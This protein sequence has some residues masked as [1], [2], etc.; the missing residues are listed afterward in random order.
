M[1]SRPAEAAPSEEPRR[2]FSVAVFARFRGR[3]LLIHHT[4]LGTWLPV[5]GEIE[6][7]ETP[8]LAAARE[9]QEETGLIG[10]FTALCGV[11]GTPR[12]LIG[13]EEH[14]AG[15]KGLHMNFAFVADVDS[16]VVRSNGEFTDHRFVDDPTTLDCPENV[17]Q[18]CAMALTESE[19]PLVHLAR[20]WLHTFNTR[21]L[22]GLLALYADDAVHTSPKLRLRHPETKGEVRGKDALRAWWKDAMERLPELRYDELHL[23]ADKRR[24]VMEYMRVCPPEESYVVAETLVVEK[25]LIVASHVF[26]G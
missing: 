24:V 2:A 17:R 25:G 21:D 13:Y 12:G 20:R 7:G 1:T 3:V 16:D 10:R 4:R 11:D 14:M 23:T 18:L 6:P 19:S 15:K 9:L 5:G 26:H 22:S 8:L